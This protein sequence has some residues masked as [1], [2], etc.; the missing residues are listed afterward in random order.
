[1]VTRT[2]LNVT[3]QSIAG[4]VS[5]TS[6]MNAI[7]VNCLLENEWRC[8][9]DVGHRVPLT[10]SR[11]VLECDNTTDSVNINH[12]DA[13]VMDRKRD[14]WCESA[15]K[16]VMFYHNWKDYKFSADE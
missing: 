12:C 1:M 6:N 9:S 8:I 5:S 13:T 10:L 15:L 2:C 4:L 16:L 3:L 7:V 14:A 11:T